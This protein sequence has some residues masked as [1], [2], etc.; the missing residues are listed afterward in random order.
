M[1]RSNPYDPLKSSNHSIFNSQDHRRS[2]LD[3]SLSSI[4]KSSMSDLKKSNTNLQSD[5]HK[6]TI[7][8]SN[9]PPLVIPKGKIILPSLSLQKKNKS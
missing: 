3:K 5:A 1:T 2:S 6:N 7:R 4:Y 9:K 8:L